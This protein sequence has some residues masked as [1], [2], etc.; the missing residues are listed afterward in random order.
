M[1]S[2]I[3]R[4]SSL[5]SDH[6]SGEEKAFSKDG[7]YFYSLCPNKNWQISFQ[8][9]MKISK[10]YICTSYLPGST[11]ISSWDVSYSNDGIS[12]ET[13]QKDSINK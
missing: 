1:A 10:Y 4:Y 8:Q 11:Y 6:G 2:I 13:L 7:S 5:Y 12:F 9:P 3:N